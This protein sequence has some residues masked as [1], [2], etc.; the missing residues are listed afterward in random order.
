MTHA[1]L[2]AKK[3]LLSAQAEFD[4]LKLTISM[5]D[6]RRV[7][8]PSL[9]AADASDRQSTTSRLLGFTMPLI[10]RS[11]IGRV[12]RAVSLALSV[13]RFLRGFR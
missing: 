11:Q 6:M 8:R 7:L 3:Q 9:A 2:E 12:M 13:Y 1:D 4:R 5:H 10:G